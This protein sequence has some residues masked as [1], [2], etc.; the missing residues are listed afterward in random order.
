MAK[1]TITIECDEEKQAWDAYTNAYNTIVN[2]NTP[3]TIEL[4]EHNTTTDYVLAN[5]DNM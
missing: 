1:Y 5:F 4:V 2:G 3:H